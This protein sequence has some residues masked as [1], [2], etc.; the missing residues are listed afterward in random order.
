VKNLLVDLDEQGRA[1]TTVEPTAR[2]RDLLDIFRRQQ[3]G[4][5]LDEQAQAIREQHLT[6]DDELAVLNQLIEQE[7]TRQGI[8]SPMEG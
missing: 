1:K 3:H 2:L 5:S 7:R 8:S 6:V 4:K